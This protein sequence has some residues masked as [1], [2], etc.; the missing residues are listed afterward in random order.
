MANLD[1]EIDFNCGRLSA[2]LSS[3]RAL[4][5]EDLQAPLAMEERN[6]EDLVKSSSCG[7]FLAPGSSV[8]IPST[9]WINRRW[10]SL[11]T[12]QVC[13]ENYT[14]ETQPY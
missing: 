14:F 5:A 8:P 13:L 6:L 10:T 7:P 3:F 4:G 12:I 11:K 1:F 2:D 9:Q